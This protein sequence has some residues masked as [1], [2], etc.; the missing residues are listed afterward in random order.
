MISL[1]R[2][3]DKQMTKGLLVIDQQMNTIIIPWDD[4]D[5]QYAMM[6]KINIANVHQHKTLKELDKDVRAYV[7]GTYKEEYT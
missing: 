2:R 4:E 6:H 1:S 3:K 5:L 7:N